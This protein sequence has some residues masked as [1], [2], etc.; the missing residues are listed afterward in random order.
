MFAT[1]TSVA[2]SSSAVSD[3][4][5]AASHTRRLVSSRLSRDPSALL[6]VDVEVDILLERRL[7]R[8]I[9]AAARR[10]YSTLSA[11]R[12]RYLAVIGTIFGRIG[13][14]L[15]VPSARVG[16]LQSINHSITFVSKQA[17]QSELT[18]DN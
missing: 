14:H 6:I 7:V 18:I 15:A 8:W 10:L 4:T 2:T 13:C 1:V 5:L 16:P 12:H 11:R 3:S 17:E 9:V